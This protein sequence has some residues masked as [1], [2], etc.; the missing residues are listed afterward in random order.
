MND[1][2]PDP[3]GPRVEP[4]GVA[5]GETPP[6]E[7]NLSGTGPRETYNPTRG[8]GKGPIIVVMIVVV[9]FAVFYIVGYF[10]R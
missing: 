5:P 7:G 2:E 1:N 10:T 8:W 6:G 4:G 3:R 9:L